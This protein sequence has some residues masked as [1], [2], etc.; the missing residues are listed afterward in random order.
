MRCG[1]LP[2]LSLQQ[3]YSISIRQEN[4]L[5]DSCQRPVIA[6]FH[7]GWRRPHLERGHPS[8]ASSDIYAF[9]VTCLEASS[10]YIGNLYCFLL[11]LTTTK[12]FTGRWGIRSP[13]YPPE[14]ISAYKLRGLHIDMWNLLYKCWSS[15]PELRP[16]IN[17]I[18][19]FPPIAKKA[20]I[21]GLINR[22]EGFSVHSSSNSASDKMREFLFTLQSQ[23]IDLGLSSSQDSRNL[24]RIFASILDKCSIN[25]LI[26]IINAQYSP[27]GCSCLIDLLH[28][29]ATFASFSSSYSSRLLP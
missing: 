4:I 17:E 18:C 3:Y 13:S 8:T 19:N 1:F 28:E 26:K 10:F 5:V 25:Y 16:T 6:G 23:L 11:M 7:N 29:V 21:R 9:A 24:E 14:S 22:V 20:R 2:Y 12:I 15:R 27:A